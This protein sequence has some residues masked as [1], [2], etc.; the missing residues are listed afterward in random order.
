MLVL[1]VAI[2]EENDSQRYISAQKNQTEMLDDVGWFTV[3]D[4]T[5]GQDL[6]PMVCDQM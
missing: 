4:E 2:L 1:A 6:E 5:S 3:K